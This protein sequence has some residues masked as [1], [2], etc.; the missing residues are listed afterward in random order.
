MDHAGVVFRASKDEG[1]HAREGA[2]TKQQY[3]RIGQKLIIYI[4][5]D[6]DPQDRA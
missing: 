5:N 2:S 4:P 3:L 1:N 6:N